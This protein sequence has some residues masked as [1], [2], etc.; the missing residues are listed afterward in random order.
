MKKLKHEAKHSTIFSRLL[1]SLFTHR[2][3]RSNKPAAFG[4]HFILE[5]QIKFNGCS[6]FNKNTF[7]TTVAY[8]KKKSFIGVSLGVYHS[9]E[10]KIRSISA[11][12]PFNSF[13][14][15]TVHCCSCV[16][17]VTAN[18]P[19]FGGPLVSV[20]SPCIPS[21]CLNQNTDTG[22]N[23]MGI[24]TGDSVRAISAH[25]VLGRK[26]VYKAS[27]SRMMEKVHQNF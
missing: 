5:D 27:L 12:Q 20:W 15:F 26:Y 17:Y 14:L 21:Y 19:Y 6:Y 18:F 9:L 1:S 24:S 10:K 7:Q 13:Q 16:Y 25:M 4:C 11:N 23:N 8:G 2:Y 3:R 22:Q